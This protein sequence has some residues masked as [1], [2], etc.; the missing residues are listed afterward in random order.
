MKR[1]RQSSYEKT[2]E[3]VVF[4]YGFICLFVHISVFALCQSDKNVIRLGGVSGGP[5][6]RR[7][8]VIVHR[9]TNIYKEIPLKIHRDTKYRAGQKMQRDP[10][11]WCVGRP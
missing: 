9:N 3:V 6:G 2:L 11:R 7:V 10:F 8:W 5:S 4:F 1:V